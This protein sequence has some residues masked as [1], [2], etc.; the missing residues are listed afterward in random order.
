MTRGGP[1]PPRCLLIT[2]ASSGIGAALAEAYAA[3]GVTLRLTGRDATRL[4]QVAYQCTAAGAVVESAVLDVTDAA[5]M[6]A[7]VLDWDAAVPFDLVIANAGISAGSGAGLESEAD[8]RQV[9]DINVIGTINTLAPLLPR[10]TARQQGHVAVMASLAGYRG[11]A[12]AAAYC[13]SKAWVKAYGE[14]LRLTLAPLGVRV[15]VICPGFVKSRITDQNKFPMPF[16]MPAPRAAQI[17][18][19]ALAANRARIA[20][21]WPM[22]TAI[23]LIAALPA[24]WADRLLQRLPQKT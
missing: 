3:P 4:A 7:T 17:I 2:G 10:L 23:H 9:T 15:S 12:G 8:L 11:L 18:K 20:F 14:A 21:P 5:A 13:A 22:A 1:V 24:A 16:L 19:R 6:A